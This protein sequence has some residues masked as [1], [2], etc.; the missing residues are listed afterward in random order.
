MTTLKLLETL[1]TEA[2]AQVEACRAAEQAAAAALQR[3][4]DATCAAEHLATVAERALDR[5]ERGAQ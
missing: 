4:R 1:A 5:L 2:R 3:A